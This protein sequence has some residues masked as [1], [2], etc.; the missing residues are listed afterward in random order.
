MTVLAPW[1]GK[2]QG[3]VIGSQDCSPTR[4]IR[5][6]VAALGLGFTGPAHAQ[7]VTTL[8]VESDYRLR[9]RSLSAERPVAIASLAY[10]HP[11]G[12][13]LAG[14]AVGAFRNGPMLVSLQGNVG[15]ARRLGSALSIDGGIV[16]SEYMSSYSDG[17]SAHYTELYLGLATRHLSSRLYYS[18]DYFRAGTET[19]Y[20]EVEAAIRP[21]PNW[22][23]NGHVGALT[24][25]RQRPAYSSRNQFDWRLGATR[26]FGAF[27]VHATVSGGAPD[28]DYYARAPRDRTAFVV[29]AVHAF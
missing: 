22:R 2:L 19:L 21:V 12:V 10:D 6:F 8:A 25:L 28:R 16:R 23:L 1:P 26:E 13:Y 4:L 7:L 24:Y 9:G 5:L 3:P 18:P 27:E 29:G 15:Y 14:S 17:R 11:T 20:A